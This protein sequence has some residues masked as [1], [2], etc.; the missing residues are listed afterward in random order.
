MTKKDLGSGMTLFHKQN[1]QT[2]V[3]RFTIQL[4]VSSDLENENNTGYLNTMA[5]MLFMGCKKYSIEQITDILENKAASINVNT[6]REGISISFTCLKSDVNLI[7]DILVNSLKNPT[8]PETEL[9]LYKESQFADSQRNLSDPETVHSDF[10]SKMIY[11]EKRDALTSSERNEIIQKI[12]RPDIINCYHQYLKANTALIAVVGDET[13]EEATALANK[14]FSNLSHEQINET[15]KPIKVS[16]QN[17]TFTQEYPFEQVNLD[18]NM[19]SANSKDPDIYVVKVILNIL[20]G[21]NGRIFKATRGK[22]NLSYFAYAYDVASPDYGIFRVTSQTSKEKSE[23]LKNVLINEINRLMTE[24]V[25]P[26]EIISAINENQKQ[27]EYYITD[28]DIATYS[29]YYENQGLGYD[30]LF[31]SSEKLKKVTP[32]DIK[33]VANK[34]FKEKDIIISY[35]SEN[36]KRMLEE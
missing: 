8:F 5:Q 18:I 31:N 34:Y 16:V 3:V 21:S 1:N 33:R 28:K 14:I 32:E 35:P 6:S 36:L 4:P 22:N 15:P 9:A 23:E 12:T 24:S 10:R 11:Q 17:K 26:D 7:S 27:M 19:L 30:Y 25:S 13:F 29:M 2:P 20:N